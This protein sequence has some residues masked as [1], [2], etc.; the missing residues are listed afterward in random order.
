MLEK[1]EKESLESDEKFTRTNR[2]TLFSKMMY[3]SYEIANHYYG[4]RCQGMVLCQ[5]L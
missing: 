1:T 5:K 4:A 3:G 2:L